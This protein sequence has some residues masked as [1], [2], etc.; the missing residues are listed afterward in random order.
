MAAAFARKRDVPGVEVLSAAIDPQ[1]APHPAASEVMKEVGVDLSADECNSLDDVPILD[2]DAVVTLFSGEERRLGFLL[3]GQPT[4]VNWRVESPE[5]RAQSGISEIDAY[6]QMRD[7]I[8]QLVA[9][10]FDHG[11]LAALAGLHD[12]NEFVL[13]SLSE[14][15]IVHDMKRRILSFNRAAE[16]ITGYSREQVIGRDC[17][18]VFE[19]SFCSG[20]CSFC[21][22]QSPEFNQVNYNLHFVTPSGEGRHLDMKVRAI[23]DANARMV[24]VLASFRDITR[25]ES[26]ARRL[27]E[28][29]QFSGIIGRDHKMLDVFDLVRSVA[30]STAP[31]LVQ[32]ESGTGKELV[33]AAI[34]NESPRANQAFVPV[35]CGALPEGL[36]ETELFGHVRGAFTGAVRDKKG[37]FEIADGG[38]IFLDEIGDISPA[39]QVKLL[40]VLQEGTFERVGDHNTLK[41]DA[42]IISATNKNLQEEI[43]A[44]RFREDLYYRLCVVPVTLPPL[45]ERRGDIPLLLTHILRRAAAQVGRDVMEVT[46]D[47]MDLIL[48]YDWPGNVRELQNA[49]QFALVKTRG[50]KVDA[51]DLPPSLTGQPRP[52]RIPDIEVPP[53]RNMAP[54]P[55]RA[56]IEADPLL[57][58]SS[59]AKGKDDA[60]AKSGSRKRRRKLDVDS[61]REA[62]SATDGN[63]V[64]ATK[65]L[66]V[67]RA[68]LYRFLDE[69]PELS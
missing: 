19:P 43:K 8:Q 36:L 32:G 59:S 62:L 67:S 68:T 22:S 51:D 63:K 45:R 33:A 7:E 11:Y 34:H 56:P 26:M 16:E 58:E 5:S 40:R 53:P 42:R 46:P 49:V 14:G 41:V 25:E 2:L 23:R 4:Q 37:R 54:G 6:R 3:P 24:G 9:D 10:F 15:I 27:G 18:D 1:G 12:S 28:I 13:D 31:V 39:M 66:G 55:L 21:E 60:S 35:N 38:T 61:V 48:A 17:H 65:R 57:D 64:Q 50:P 47:A 44:G 20:Q 30:D 52:L 69:H 29:E